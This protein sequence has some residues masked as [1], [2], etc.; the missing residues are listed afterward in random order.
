[1]Q[2]HRKHFYVFRTLAHGE[3]ICYLNTIV[4]LEVWKRFGEHIK[5]ASKYDK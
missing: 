1:M 3:K 5:Q 4:V 2:H